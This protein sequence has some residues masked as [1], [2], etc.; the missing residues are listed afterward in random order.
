MKEKTG[1][2]SEGYFGSVRFFRH[3][4][5]LCLFLI[6]VTPYLCVMVLFYQNKLLRSEVT[7]LRSR[8]LDIGASPDVALIPEDRKIISSPE[9]QKKYPDLYCTP[10]TLFVK[11]EKTVYLTFDDGPSRH[12][13]KILRILGKYNIK[14]TFFAVGKNDPKSKKIMRQIVEEGHTLAPH[15]YTHAYNKIYTSVDLFLDDFK[16]IND[17][18]YETTGVRPNILRFPGGTVNVYNRRIFRELSAEML[19]RGYTFY[20]WDVSAADATKSATADS[21]MKSIIYGVHENRRNIVLMHDTSEKTLKALEKTIIYLK[22]KGFAFD[23]L[24]NEVEPVTFYYNYPEKGG[25]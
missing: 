14:A 19:R 5:Y 9:Y 20:D 21:V 12:T 4:V 6:V 1:V 7:A 3:I 8:S 11:K 2:K 17:L 16:K 23:R 10:R 22:N 18:I 13:D 24:T 25:V 15:S